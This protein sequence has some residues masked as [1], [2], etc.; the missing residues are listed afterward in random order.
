[1]DSR[2]TWTAVMNE[3][4]YIFFIQVLIIHREDKKNAVFQIEMET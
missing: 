4:D 2:G 3:A 1:M